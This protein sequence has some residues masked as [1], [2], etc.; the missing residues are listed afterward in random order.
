MDRSVLAQLEN[1][2]YRK[3][4]KRTQIRKV[5]KIIGQRWK[6]EQTIG[7]AFSEGQSQ[8]FF[9]LRNIVNSQYVAAVLFHTVY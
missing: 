6:I 5:G 8:F 9:L 2:F 3:P 1:Y 4:V 7:G